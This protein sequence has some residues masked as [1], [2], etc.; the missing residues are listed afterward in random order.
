MLADTAVAVNPTD[1]RYEALIGGHCVLPLVGR[2]LPVIAD[3]HVDPEFGTGALKIT[4]GHDP[5]DFEIGRAHG[6]EE[7]TV[8]GEDGLMTAE[9]G[10][11]FAGLTT[12][13]AREAVLAA[14]RAEGLLRG[15]EPYMH[16]VPFSHRSG[17]RIEPLISLQWFCHMDE[18]AKPAIEVVERDRVRIVPEQHKRVYLDW[19]QNIRPWCISR[20]LWWGHRL[21]VWYCDACEETFVAETPPDRCGSCGGELR[22]DE[23]VLDTWFSSALWPFAV[24]GWPER[25]PGA[26]RLLPH[27]RAGHGAG[28]HLPLGGPDGDDGPGVRRRRPL[29]RRLHHPGDPSARRAADV[30]EPRHR[31]RP[32]GRDRR[33]RRRRRPLRPAGDVVGAGRALLGRS[34]PAGPGPGE[35]D[36]ERVAADPAERHRRARSRLPPG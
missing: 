28:H 23:D 25:D 6:L 33:P 36:V 13:E 24:L 26:A 21:P 1:Q 32:A 31:H 5:N 19:M 15:E 12:E 3:E 20:Q 9:A 10:E 29:R 22:Q 17:Q 14:L 7:V 34:D 30:E 18:L 11:R 8:I 4:P 27:R 16:S 35:Q 2:R